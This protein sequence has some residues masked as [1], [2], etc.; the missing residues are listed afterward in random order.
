[1]NPEEP[2]AVSTSRLLEEL[3]IFD[4]S[5]ARSPVEGLLH[6]VRIRRQLSTELVLLSAAELSLLP[7]PAEG[8]MP[9]PFEE[10]LPL[11]PLEAPIR[12]S[13]WAAYVATLKTDCVITRVC[14][15]SL[16]D[17]SIFT[18]DY[19]KFM[20]VGRFLRAQSL[21]EN[22]DDLFEGVEADYSRSPLP[23]GGWLRS[24]GFVR[25][26]GVLWK[27]KLGMILRE[28]DIRHPLQEYVARFGLTN[29]T[30]AE[31]SAPTDV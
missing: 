29:P 6:E 5:A 21:W 10:P 15:L 18:G 19:S 4:F 27:A 2:P 1:M 25:V 31:G 20:R 28:T 30:A 9:D 3:Q 17:L 22:F 11:V 14:R 16:T 7:A 13:Q 8:D 24:R 23:L 12:V 26:Q